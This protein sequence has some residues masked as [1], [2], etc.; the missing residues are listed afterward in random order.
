[1]EKSSLGTI[2]VTPSLVVMV[3]LVSSTAN[4]FQG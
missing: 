4:V 1:M 3:G 2:F